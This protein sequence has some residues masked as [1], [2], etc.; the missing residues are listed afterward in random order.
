[1]P[2]KVRV[3]PGSSAD[4][5]LMNKLLGQDMALGTQPMP[6]GGELCAVKVEAVRAWINA[7]APLN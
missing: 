6:F 3:A 4:S 5:Y 1:V 7:G 2:S